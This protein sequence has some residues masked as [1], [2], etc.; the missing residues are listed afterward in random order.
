M[1]GEDYEA[2]PLSVGLEVGTSLRGSTQRCGGALLCG[3][4]SSVTVCVDRFYEETV[5]SKT[6]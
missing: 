3:P 1:A 6:V 2:S 4:C 5:G